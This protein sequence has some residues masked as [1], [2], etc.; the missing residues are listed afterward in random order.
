MTTPS[1]WLVEAITEIIDSMAEEAVA[2]TS[3]QR[4]SYRS[5][6]DALNGLLGLALAEDGDLVFP[7]VDLGNQI[8]A[9]LATQTTAPA[10]VRAPLE[11]LIKSLDTWVERTMLAGDLEQPR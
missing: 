9:D 8:Y 2:A 1:N 10:G 6:L 5:C 11:D 3:D 7:M 4:Q